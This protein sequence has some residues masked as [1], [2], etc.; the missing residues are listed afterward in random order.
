M[1]RNHLQLPS[2]VRLGIAQ[3]LIIILTIILYLPVAFAT[4][5]DTTPR[6]RTAAAPLASIVTV[7]ISGDGDNLDPNS[8]CDT[9]AVASGEQCSLRAAVQRAN[10]LAGDD[11]ITFNIPAATQ[12]NC[13]LASGHCTINLFKPLDD[14]STNVRIVSPV[15]DKITV[16]RNGAAS[17]FRVF[18]VTS[19][20]EV[21]F[22]G[23][24]VENGRPSGIAA[25]GAIA[26]DG[27][28]IVNIVDSIF[29]DNIGGTIVASG[30]ALANNNNGTMNVVNC[31]FADNHATSSGG[32][33]INGGSG[34]LNIISSIILHND[35]TVPVV[36][37]ANGN[38]GGVSNINNGTVNIT[39]SVIADN[40]VDG[41][42]SNTS[43]LRG[44]GV[45]NLGNGAI[46]VTGSVVS[47][48]FSRKDGGGISNTSGTLHVTNSTITQN[49][50]LGGGIFG[51]GTIKSSI[52]A[53]NNAGSF[54][55]SDVSGVFVSEGF[56]LIGV[57][58]GATGFTVPSDLKGTAAAPLDPKFDPNGVALPGMPLPVPGLP[59]CGS[60]AIDKGSSDGLTTDLRGAGFPRT[61]DD[62][63]ESNAA[64]GADIGAF[65]RQTICAQI[66][67]TVNNTSDA[68]DA[69]PGDG[70]CDSD[71]VTT[72]A[73]CSLRAALRESNEIGGDYT[74]NFSIPTSDP[75]FD[76][77]TSQHTINLTGALPE[78]TNSNLIIN[79]PGKDKL[80]VRRNTGGFYRIFT[81]GGVVESATISGLTVSNGFHNVNDGGALSFTGKTLNIN[82]C[83][84]SNNI[85]AW[86]G[87]AINA[88]AKLT[89]TDSVFNNNF[90]TATG[91]FS[92][93]GA[94][95]VRGPINVSNST[96]NDNVANAMG[97]A[98]NS[99]STVGAGGDS[100][101]TN[102]T[103]NGNGA[104]AGGGVAVSTATGAQPTAMR[105]T[106]STFRRN[107]ASLINSRGGAIY[108]MFGTLYVSG[109]TLS[110]NE[111]YGLAINIGSGSTATTVTDSTIS[112][113]TFGG[114]ETELSTATTSKLNI[115]NSTISGNKG[116][117]GLSLTRLTLNVSNST[118]SNNES[119]GI[120]S[121]LSGSSGTW[122]IKS[123]IIAANAGGIGDLNGTFTSGGYNLIGNPST[124]TG[125]ANG[126]NND[127]VGSSGAPLD[128]KLDPLGLQDNGGTTQ[129]IALQADSP[130]IDKGSSEALSGKLDKDQ[131]Q[132]FARTFDDAAMPNSGDGTDIG[133]FELQ[134]GGPTPTPTPTP[135]PNPSP[136]PTPT[137]N[138]SPSPS[139]SPSPTPTPVPGSPR[140]VVTTTV[141]VRTGCGD[142][143][144]G[145][146]VQNTGGA[147][148]NNV[149]LTT[150]TLA[151]PTVNGA[152][153]P[154]NFGNLAPGQWAT[155][156]IIFPGKNN[157]SGSKRT[158]TFA[159]TYSG[160]TFDGKWK[161]TLP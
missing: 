121:L 33:I 128:P 73:Q 131:R 85:A 77:S 14:L 101:I 66:T 87:G 111:S 62:P 161:V 15:M 25:G 123:S 17:D 52:I 130:A 152:P 70:T 149:K 157:L 6:T 93:G 26:H 146:T 114:I 31:F 3:G 104:D 147:T 21:T 72:G 54:A 153:L 117:S 138:P 82:S 90:S 61:V 136:S 71:T 53:K 1:K 154:N 37:N 28:G 89:V 79:G 160:G 76:P 11:E 44:A 23:L 92:G 122:T 144:V 74:I 19:A 9:D 24:R 139:P 105:I 5:S 38:G 102:S 48:N 16:R 83:E 12:P 148:A 56:N 120:R 109:S 132:V 116:G 110:D 137:P 84:F 86:S 96:F 40:K 124:A 80:T 2:F 103:F 78:I 58:D 143:A 36:A 43:S 113:N 47:N 49:R 68:D 32:A 60:P 133:A 125:F 51:Q 140:I 145:V 10:A 108:H 91:G 63:D 64:D 119:A 55:G 29:T 30:G 94:I 156:V 46:N 159:G 126:V 7:N 98:V 13:D 35:V 134:P 39:N 99:D 106:D 107:T 100:S 127:L 27:A 67:F 75:G 20:S 45:M 155:T 18:R 141:L 41:G 65:E 95:L 115:I 34:T 22:S 142:I 129:T 42:D 59:L 118:I 4:A 97:G 158:L 8:G 112:G 88:F 150:G 81:F 151:S 69:N 50:G 135:T 57:A